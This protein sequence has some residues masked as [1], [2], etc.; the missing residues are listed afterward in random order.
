[1]I[2]LCYFLLIE[3]SLIYG[4]VF[5]AIFAGLVLNILYFTKKGGLARKKRKEAALEETRHFARIFMSKFESLQNN[6]T[7]N[8][9]KKLCDLKDEKVFYSKISHSWSFGSWQLSRLMLII[10]ALGICWQLYI[11]AKNIGV[12]STLIAQAGTVL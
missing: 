11:S 12:T 10:F 6:Q 4:I 8:L 3:V 2:I 7:Q 9:I 1:L 5:L